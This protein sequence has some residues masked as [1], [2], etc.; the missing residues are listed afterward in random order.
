[1]VAALKGIQLLTKAKTENDIDN[2]VD[3]LT[4]FL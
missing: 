2:Y 3:Y 4:S 1:M